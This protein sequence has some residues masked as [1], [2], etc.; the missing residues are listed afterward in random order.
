MKEA[1]AIP[2]ILYLF[3]S[4]L[5]NGSGFD[6]PALS[7]DRIMVIDSMI[8]QTVFNLVNSLSKTPNVD[9]PYIRVRKALASLP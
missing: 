2:Q 3:L 5:L 1:G 6:Q 7:N 8:K 9:V 4:N